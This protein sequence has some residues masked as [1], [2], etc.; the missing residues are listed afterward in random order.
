M[1]LAATFMNFSYISYILIEQLEAANR[2][3][4]DLEVQVSLEMQAKDEL[5]HNYRSEHLE[6]F[7]NQLA[8]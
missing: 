7:N 4:R 1:W 2:R 3:I 5:D 8:D 6:S